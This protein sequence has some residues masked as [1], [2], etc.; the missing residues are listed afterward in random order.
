LTSVFRPV[1]I[2]IFKIVIPTNNEQSD[3][4]STGETSQKRNQ[5]EYYAC[6]NR[7]I[8]PATKGQSLFGFYFLNPFE[9]RS[10]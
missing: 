8:Y 10:K 9:N 4:P 1:G 3:S 6:E 2:T 5:S 7:N